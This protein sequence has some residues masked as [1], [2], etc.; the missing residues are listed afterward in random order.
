M[1][2]LAESSVLTGPCEGR[3]VFTP[4]VAGM[5][6]IFDPDVQILV[7]TRDTPDALS[8]YIECAASRMSA[9]SRMLIGAEGHLPESALPVLPDQPD[10][11]GRFLMQSDIRMLVEAFSDLMDCPTV[12][13]RLEV[14]QRAMCPRFHTDH[15]GIRLLCAYRG[16]GTQWIDEKGANRQK[17][18]RGAQGAPDESSGLMPPGAQ[19]HTVEKFHVALLKGDLWQGNAGRG[20]IHRSPEITPST[21]PRVLLAL[22]AVWPD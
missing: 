7:W 19:I 1:N 14:L 13:L 21:A 20:V 10:H 3:A 11:E 22:D 5:T 9:S 6:G 16:K 15:V 17:L 2:M 4:G 18:G 12:A 8:D